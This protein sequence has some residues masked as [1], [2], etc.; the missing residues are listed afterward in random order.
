[1]AIHAG[2][3][4]WYCG[5]GSGLGTRMTIETIDPQCSRV[6]LVTESDRLGR[7]VPRLSTLGPKY[8]G[9]ERHT[10]R[11]GEEQNTGG[12]VDPPLEF[13]AKHQK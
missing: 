10:Q 12:E 8:E 6:K 1:M 11:T 3:N 9:P 5:V 13:P 7:L 4:R 2:R